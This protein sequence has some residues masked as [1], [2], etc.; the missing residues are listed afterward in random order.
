MNFIRFHKMTSLLA[1][2]LFFTL[3]AC[4][5][6][7]NNEA[8]ELDIVQVAD[9]AGFNTLV[10]AVKAADLESTLKGPGPFTVFAPTDAAFAGLPSGTL[11]NLLL[12]ENKDL[13]ASI[14]TYHVV[15]GEVTSE[16]VVGLTTATTVQGEMLDIVVENGTVMINGVAVTQTDI[17]AANGII[18]IIDGVLLPPSVQ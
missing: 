17:T 2:L 14:L 6:T 11:D 8:P 9:D 7:D 15:A 3:S 10:A 1:F 13:L 12:P 18:H 4:D 16:Q 5:S